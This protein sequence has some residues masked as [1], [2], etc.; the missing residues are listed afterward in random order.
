MQNAFEKQKARKRICFFSK[1]L[2]VNPRN[3]PT[4]GKKG[5]KIK[6][7]ACASSFQRFFGN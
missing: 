4:S 5:I 3:L 7:N 6:S 2:R 1:E